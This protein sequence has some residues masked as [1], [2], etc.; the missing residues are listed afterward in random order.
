MMRFVQT[1]NQ[2]SRVL[3]EA[4]ATI[5]NLS[6]ID[7]THPFLNKI[8]TLKVAP[9]P[10]ATHIIFFRLAGPVQPVEQADRY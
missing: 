3:V 4:V 10:L 2:D 7:E 6:A 8:P 9:G 5:S 1:P